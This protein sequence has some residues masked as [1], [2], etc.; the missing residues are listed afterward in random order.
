MFSDA[1]MVGLIRGRHPMP[2]DQFVWEED[3]S[4]PTNFAAI[5]QHA[6]DWVKDHC[7]IGTCHQRAIDQANVGL[8]PDEITVNKGLPVVLYVTGLAACVTAMLWACAKYG[9]PLRL[10]HFDR[11]T[12][13]YVPQDFVRGLS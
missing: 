12:G 10:M 5:R 3:I 1:I 2:V 7:R 9:V 11:D 8:D 6:E 4:D 13:S